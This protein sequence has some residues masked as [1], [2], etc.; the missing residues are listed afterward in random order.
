MKR[1]IYKPNNFTNCQLFEPY[2]FEASNSSKTNY[3]LLLGAPF[4]FE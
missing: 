3:K 1:H 4:E 2:T